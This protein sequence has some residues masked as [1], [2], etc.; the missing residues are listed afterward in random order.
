[1]G[2]LV[3]GFFILS[4]LFII[5]FF[6]KK[7]KSADSF[8]ETSKI[9]K[10]HLIV[11][12]GASDPVHHICSRIISTKIAVENFSYFQWYQF[13][14]ACKF[15]NSIQ[16]SKKIILLGHSWGGKTAAKVFNKYSEK[17]TLL[18]TLDPVS[19]K[20]PCI[21]PSMKNTLWINI[22]PTFEKL[23]WNALIATV[24]GRWKKQA[25][26]QNITIICDHCSVDKMLDAKT[27]D[28][29]TIW[30]II[31]NKMKS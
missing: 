28:G 1:M 24:G 6:W 17:I 16:D 20:R 21:H 19:W 30:H 5:I 29:K 15:I 14:D 22:V 2:W 10:S 31:L 13:E 26:A 12:G 11:F 25:G 18:I 27:S 8:V 3:I 4:V 9:Y 23:S 7:S